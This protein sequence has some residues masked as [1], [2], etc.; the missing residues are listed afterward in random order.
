MSLHTLTIDDFMQLSKQNLEY[1]LRIFQQE[2]DGTLALLREEEGAG[3]DEHTLDELHHVLTLRKVFTL[4][5]QEL[6]DEQPAP[7]QLTQQVANQYEQNA[8][9][10]ALVS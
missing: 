4:R 6:Q 8:R 10:P 5:L 3:R 7:H 9:Q 1:A 2:L